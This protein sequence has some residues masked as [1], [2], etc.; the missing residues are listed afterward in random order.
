M[1]LTHTR[2]PELAITSEKCGKLLKFFNSETR[3][4]RVKTIFYRL[5]VPPGRRYRCRHQRPV[6]HKLAVIVATIEMRYA[7]LMS[8]RAKGRPLGCESDKKDGREEAR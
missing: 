8:L 6:A 7:V 5:S 1:E 4:F 3:I 2:S